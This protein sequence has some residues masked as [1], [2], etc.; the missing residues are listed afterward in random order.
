ME[1]KEEIEFEKNQ[2]LKHN[3]MESEEFD[4]MDNIVNKVVEKILSIRSSEGLFEKGIAYGSGIFLRFKNGNTYRIG[5]E[6]YNSEIVLDKVE[7]SPTIPL[8]K[9]LRFAE[10]LPE[11]GWEKWIKKG[12]WG[13]EQYSKPKNTSELYKLFLESSKE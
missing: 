4:I 6:K 13:H 3:E 11:H 9:V 5:I 1:N 2:F 8:A 7:D 12:L 10:W